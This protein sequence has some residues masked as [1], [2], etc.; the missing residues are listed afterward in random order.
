MFQC[1][2]QFEVKKI[3]L[4]KSSL[5]KVRLSHQSDCSLFEQGGEILD[6]GHKGISMKS[7]L[8]HCT[9]RGQFRAVGVKTR[10][11]YGMFL[12]VSFM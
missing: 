3:L 9:P 1:S 8:N 4:V 7:D 12:Y 5:H 10:S 11:I 2:V 6:F